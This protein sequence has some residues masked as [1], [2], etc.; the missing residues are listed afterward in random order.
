MAD[1]AFE[2]VVERWTVGQ[3]RTALQGLPDD[4]P[5]VVH[6]AEEPGG[7]TADEQIITHADTDAFVARDGTE[8]AAGE[9]Q[10]QCEFP[11]GTYY[12]RRHYPE[13]TS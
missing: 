3:L 2:H 13:G 10:I 7:D 6:V 5:V 12:R 4:M 9:L 11:T 1:E 8:Y